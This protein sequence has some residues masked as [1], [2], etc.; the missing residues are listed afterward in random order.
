MVVMHRMMFI[1]F[2]GLVRGV[3]FDENLLY[4]ITPIPA[5]ILPQVNTLVYS[6]WV[7]ELKGQDQQLPNGTIIPYR[8]TSKQRHLMTTPHRRF[9]P[10]QLLKMSRKS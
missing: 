5:Y 2:A 3:D 1:I 7:P 10:I 4:I 8:T 9:N 6:D